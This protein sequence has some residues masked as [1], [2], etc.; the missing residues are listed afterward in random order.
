MPVTTILPPQAFARKEKDEPFV[1]I[2]FV[3]TP[4]TSAAALDKL[5]VAIKQFAIVCKKPEILQGGARLELTVEMNGKIV[6]SKMLVDGQ[7][8]KDVHFRVRKW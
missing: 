1:T 3:S 6:S 4:L 7:E 2:Y 8:D 5:K